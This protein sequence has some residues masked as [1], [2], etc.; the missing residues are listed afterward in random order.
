MLRDHYGTD[1]LHSFLALLLLFQKL[2]LA[3]NIASV[4]LGSDILSKG[5][6]SGARDYLSPNSALDEGRV[7]KI[8]RTGQH[9]EVEGSVE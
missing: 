9:G 2:S 4:A 1:H 5:L 6:D 3:G 8:G 7:E